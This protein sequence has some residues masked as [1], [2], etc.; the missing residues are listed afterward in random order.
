MLPEVALDVGFISPVQTWGLGLAVVRELAW[1]LRAVLGEV[2]KWRVYAAEI[3]DPTIRRDALVALRHKR[4]NTD[5]AALLWTLTDRRCLSL[6][7]LL[8]AYEIMG[9][10]LDSAVERGM[11]VGV[12]D[13]RQLH[14]ALVEAIDVKRPLSDY[15]SEHPWRDDGGYLARLV[16][17]CRFGC[18]LLPSYSSVRPL[19]VRA[20]MLAQVQGLNH[21]QDLALRQIVLEA[22]VEREGNADSEL[23]WYEIAGAASAWLTVLALMAVAAEPAPAGEQAFE[24]FL[25]YFP[26]IALA[27][28][29]LDSYD[30]LLD[31]RRTGAHSYL[32]AYGSLELAVLRIDQLVRRATLE[33]RALRHGERHAVIVASMIALYLSKDSVR[34]VGMAKASRGILRSA[35]PLAVLLS[36]VLRA[37]RLI[38]RLGDT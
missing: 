9:D 30:D 36:P 6:L 35:G 29:L 22:W 31:D 16:R 26:W 38:N 11:E 27:A 2:E 14:L 21:E 1:G 4:P 15:Y 19:L 34:S 7:R 13:G 18:L 33:A 23:D 3:P 32:A 24:V 5:G 8:V 20:A 25:A 28:T 17:A 12:V 37:W 10:F